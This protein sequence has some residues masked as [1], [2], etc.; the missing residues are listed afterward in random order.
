MTHVIFHIKTPVPIRS[1][2]DS[3]DGEGLTTRTR[4][5]IE[6]FVDSLKSTMKEDYWFCAT[7]A[8]GDHVALPSWMG[9]DQDDFYNILTAAMHVGKP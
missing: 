1:G 2:F 8:Y 5:S 4:T 3:N 9:M 7:R 6:E